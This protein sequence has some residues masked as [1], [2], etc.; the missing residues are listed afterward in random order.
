MKEGNKKLNIQD[1]VNRADNNY[2]EAKALFEKGFYEGTTSRAY[3]AAFHMT[4]GVLLTEQFQPK[5][6]QGALYLFN[7]HFVKT[8]KFDARYSQIL[9][10][11]QKYREEADYR[12][13]MTFSKEQ[14]DETLKDVYKFLEALTRYL[15][16]SGYTAQRKRSQGT[17]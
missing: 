10:R 8:G 11:A 6:H 5:T 16:K 1:E 9:A 13:T 4:L 14:A 15:S 17:T 2:K 12:H 7:H 3:Y